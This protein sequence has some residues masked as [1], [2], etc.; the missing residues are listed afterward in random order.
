M[1][2]NEKTDTLP[3]EKVH[4]WPTSISWMFAELLIV[5]TPLASSLQLSVFFH[6]NNPPGAHYSRHQNVIGFASPPL[7]PIPLFWGNNRITWPYWW[8]QRTIPTSPFNSPLGLNHILI[9]R[10]IRFIFVTP[11]GTTSDWHWIEFLGCRYG[12]WLT[13][14]END[15][16]LGMLHGMAD[17]MLVLLIIPCP[18][19]I[20][21]AFLPN[22][23]LS[24]SLP[25]SLSSLIYSSAYFFLPINSWLVCCCLASISILPH[26]QP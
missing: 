14:L 10:F 5:T 21:A 3:E 15:C 1:I 9:I 19:Y 4:S 6:N 24:L 16:S 25:L 13:F 20:D 17:P 11:L 7:R 23:E 18:P 8:P 2:W 12:F 22:Q 26:S